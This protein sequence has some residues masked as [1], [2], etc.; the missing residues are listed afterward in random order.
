MLTIGSLPTN[1]EG[2]S[3]Y[4]IW[5]NRLTIPGDDQ[6]RAYNNQSTSRSPYLC[7]W[8]ET[9]SLGRF[10]EYAVD[11]K[12]DIVPEYTYCSLA[13]FFLDYSALDSQYANVHCDSIS[14]YA[15]FQKK[16]QEDAPNA[17][18]SFWDIYCENS[19]GQVEKIIR[20]KLI[21]PEESGNESFGGEG[22][23]AHHLTDYPWKAG[24]W[25][26]MLLQCGVS[27]TTK[28]TTI[29][30]W[31]CDLSTNQWTKLCEYD[32]GIPGVAFCGN[33][34]VFLEN[35][36]PKTSGNIRTMEIKNVRVKREGDSVW[37]N[38]ANGTF[39]Q[40]YNYI[41]SYNYGVENDAFWMVTTGVPGMSEE[42]GATK[43][44]VSGGDL[45]APYA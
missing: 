45:S 44:T 12:A 25:Y 15:G 21:F 1:A 17:I 11:F 13:N 14:G 31:A 24:N 16:S 10:T 5:Q 42:K 20:P 26:R 18:L 30:Q 29:V 22:T 40:N 28:N 8:M 33:V 41:G 6:I 35:F 36:A 4:G 34:A 37:T 9:G 7:G 43:L 19:S 39:S 38:I 32:I 3:G 2:V 23:G 27:E